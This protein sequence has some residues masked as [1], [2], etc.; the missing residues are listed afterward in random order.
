M[1][2]VEHK[3]FPHLDECK[4]LL[5]LLSRLRPYAIIRFKYSSVVFK[6]QMAAILNTSLLYKNVLLLA[7]K[8]KEIFICDSAWM[9]FDL[10]EGLRSGEKE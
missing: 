2:K 3:S 5:P 9:C 4:Q 10:Y 6:Q 1:N 7:E 8:P